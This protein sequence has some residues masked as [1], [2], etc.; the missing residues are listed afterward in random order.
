MVI[1]EFRLSCPEENMVL[2]N[3][4]VSFNGLVGIDWDALLVLLPPLE[5]LGR[6]VFVIPRVLGTLAVPV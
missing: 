1:L 5:P 2:E 3:V 4:D 6:G